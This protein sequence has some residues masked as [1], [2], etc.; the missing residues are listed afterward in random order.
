MK[1]FVWA[2]AVVFIAVTTGLSQSASDR[3]NPV[4]NGKPMEW[5]S[6]YEAVDMKS[7]IAYKFTEITQLPD[8]SEDRIYTLVEDVVTHDRLL[9][10]HRINYMDHE[11]S[12]EITDLDTHEVAAAASPLPYVSITRSGA[13]D[14]IHKNPTLRSW[15]VPSITLSVN[16]VS[17]VASE[18]EWLS[19]VTRDKR[20]AVRR[21]ASPQFLEKL[22]RLRVVGSSDSPLFHACSNVLTYFLYNEQCKAQAVHAVIAAPDCAFDAS[23]QFN[24]S[25]KSKQR[26]AKAKEAGESLER[27]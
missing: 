3:A 17:Q 16:G 9:V 24:C 23:F 25:E 7:G 26:I 27:Y 13:L 2:V 18:N 19:T 1:S 14:E 6:H 11:V 21:A 5:R 22:E 8:E 20:S 10:K 15:R 12:V 4:A